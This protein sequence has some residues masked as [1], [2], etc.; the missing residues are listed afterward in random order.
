MPD[1]DEAEDPLATA[2]E[3]LAERHDRITLDGRIIKLESP[4]MGDTGFAALKIIGVA[5]SAHPVG[6]AT[7]GPA[8]VSIGVW[9]PPDL[10]LARW[11]SKRWVVGYKLPKGSRPVDYISSEGRIPSRL[12]KGN[13]YGDDVPDDILLAF[14]E[15]GLDLD[16]PPF[17]PPPP[18]PPPE[19]KPAVK[20]AP[21]SRSVAIGGP[22][23][24]RPA[25]A[26]RTPA[27]RKPPEP[28][29]EPPPT[30]KLCPSCGMIKK[31]TQFEA[32]SE[33]CVDCR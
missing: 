12:E 29:P 4:V 26:P 25:A 7:F 28:K 14:A 16:E 21:G 18:P 20:R 11:T 2:L 1:D 23:A 22:K 6:V 30:D 9:N 31:L 32:G 27:S 24:T 10:Y 15:V 17:E 19:P 5:Q 33:F 13:W 3:L 8:S